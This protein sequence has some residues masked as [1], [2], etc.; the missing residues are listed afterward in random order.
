MKSA[1]VKSKGRLELY[2]FL[3]TLLE[4]FN[5]VSVRALYMLRESR[6]FIFFLSRE[7]GKYWRENKYRRRVFQ[8]IVRGFCRY[9]N[10][11]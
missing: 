4:G 10:E 5:I 7:Q 1:A 6:Y 9:I 11:K 3:K 2:T 8:K